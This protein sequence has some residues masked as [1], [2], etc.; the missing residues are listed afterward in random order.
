MCGIAQLF[1]NGGKEKSAR[2]SDFNNMSYMHRVAHEH[3]TQARSLTQPKRAAGQTASFLQQFHKVTAPPRLPRQFPPYRA[4]P[5]RASRSFLPLAPR[6][7]P[8]RVLAPQ[9]LSRSRFCCVRVDAALCV[10][11][12]CSSVLAG[13]AC[14]LVFVFF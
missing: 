3:V 10:S 9:A 13:F 6:C 8:A 5:C 12:S 1:N 7:A 14:L 11:L 4:L 2:T